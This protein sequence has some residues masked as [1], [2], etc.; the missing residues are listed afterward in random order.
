[1]MRGL[2][3]VG[4]LILGFALGYNFGFSNAWERAA[5]QGVQITR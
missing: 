5:Q 3:V 1:M 2:I 4:A